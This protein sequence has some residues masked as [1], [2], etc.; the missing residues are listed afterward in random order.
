MT[1]SDNCPGETLLQTAGL[2]S[3]S[4]FPV[5][6]TTNT[7]EV[8]DASGNTA[9]CSFYVTVND[10]EPP[11]ANCAA[12]FTVQLDASGNATISVT[13]IDNG[14]T[15]NCGIASLSIDPSS[16]TCAD[17][18]PNTVTLTVTDVNGNTSTCTTIVT[19]EDNVP[20]VAVCMDIIVQLDANGEATITGADVDGGSTDNC[21]IAS[22]D[23]SPNTFTCADVGLNTVT[24]TV[25][26]VNGN[27]STCTATVTVEDS[28][29][30]V[31]VCMDITVQLDANGEATITGADVDGG[32]TDACGI[33]SLDVSPS[34]F[35]CSNVGPNT[36]T[37]TVTD[38]NGNSSTCTATVT[39]ED[40]VPPV[41]ACPMDISVSTDPGICGAEVFFADAVALDACGIDTVIQ[42]QGP[43]SGSTFPVGD[44]LIEFTATDVNGNSTACTFTVTVA[45]DDAPTAVCQDITVQLDANGQ[46]TITAGDIDGG[47]SDNCAIDTISASPTSFDCSDVGDNPVTLT[48]TDIYGNSSTCTAIVTVEDNVA[49]AASCMDITV[50]LDANGQA[51]ITGADVDGGSSDACGI[52][53]ATTY[54][55]DPSSSLP[56]LTGD[57]VVHGPVPLTPAEFLAGPDS[58]KLHAAQLESAPCR[59]VVVHRL[60]TDMPDCVVAKQPADHQ[61][62][63]FHAVAPAA[64]LR[65]DPRAD[66]SAPHEAVVRTVILIANMPARCQ[67]L[68]G[69]AAVLR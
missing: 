56:L 20:P 32:S 48:V 36:V 19:V 25:T 27:S 4:V 40:S 61:P 35:D 24:L 3:G 5:G 47:S 29:P 17:V 30:P 54:N 39:V 58:V 9:S 59:M 2:A 10:T 66:H 18:G 13:D 41:I 50:E 45:D 43:P 38:V 26:D 51:T 31:A 57:A 14:S 67:L 34:M 8:T 15:D 49:P 69:K 11:V 65:V 33:A 68:H 1:T 55:L 46:A 21:G 12:P 7:F 63:G 37:L 53:S 6:T 23:V 62:L 22:L 16:F 52:A 42:T 28:V 60:R 64:Q 44:T